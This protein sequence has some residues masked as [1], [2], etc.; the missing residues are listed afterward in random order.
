MDQMLAKIVLFAADVIESQWDDCGPS[1][2]GQ[3]ILEH[4]ESVG[5]IVWRK[6]TPSELAD[7]EWW[8]HEFDIGPDT[9]GVGELSPSFRKMK[10]AAKIA[11]TKSV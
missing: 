7:R 8:G 4:A 10:T 1:E 3:M 6:P 9:S 5:L 11:T 2:D